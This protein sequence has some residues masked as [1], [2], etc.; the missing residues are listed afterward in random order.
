VTP[1][2]DTVAYHRRQ[3]RPLFI[4]SAMDKADEYAEIRRV[5]ARREADQQVQNAR[6]EGLMGVIA[7]MAIALG[8]AWFSR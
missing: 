5:L 2:E 4:V 3:A 7:V 1:A 6:F 8:I